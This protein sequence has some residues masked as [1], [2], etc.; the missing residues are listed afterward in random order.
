MGEVIHR[1]IGEVL[2]DNVIKQ[3]LQ[4]IASRK[5]VKYLEESPFIEFRIAKQSDGHYIVHPIGKDGETLD[6]IWIV[7]D[8][9]KNEQSL[10]WDE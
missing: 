6:M 9:V 10:F 8:A 4:D 1:K 7:T 3:M 5:L 2:S